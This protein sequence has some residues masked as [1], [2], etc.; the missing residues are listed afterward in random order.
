MGIRHVAHTIG[1]GVGPLTVGLLWSRNSNWLFK[2]KAYFTSLSMLCILILFL[3]DWLRS[4]QIHNERLEAS[5]KPK[6]LEKDVNKTEMADI[7]RIGMEIGDSNIPGSDGSG[8]IQWNEA[9]ATFSPNRE[10]VGL[11]TRTGRGSSDDSGVYRP[12]SLRS[13]EKE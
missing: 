13:K 2:A 8:S 11:N 4:T 9:Y 12:K 6:P 5:S 3:F 7:H 10:R 1:E